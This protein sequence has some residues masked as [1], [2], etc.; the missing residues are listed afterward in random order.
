MRE[1]GR[2]SL[3]RQSASLPLV[4]LF[5]LPPLIPCW[6]TA[7]DYS[8]EYIKGYD[9]SYKAY[10]PTDATHSSFDNTPYLPVEDFDIA[11]ISKEK[12]KVIKLLLWSHVPAG[13]PSL[14]F[15]STLDNLESGLLGLRLWMAFSGSVITLTP[16]A[17]LPAYCAG[18]SCSS[19]EICEPHFYCVMKLGITS[20]Y[21]NRNELFAAV[22]DE[23][24]RACLAE[25]Y[26][27]NPVT[28]DPSIWAC[29][30]SLTS[31]EYDIPELAPDQTAPCDGPQYDFTSDNWKAHKVEKNLKIALED[32]V[33]EYGVF[34]EA[35][36]GQEP[37]AT[38]IG[39]QFWN[40]KSEQCSIKNPCEEQDIDCHNIGSFTGLALSSLGRPMK[41]PW[42]VLV[43]AAVKNLN[44]QLVNI[45]NQVLNAIQ[46]LALDAFSTEDFSP[47]KNPNTD[48]K[49]NLA[50]L[51]SIFTILGG[52]VPVAG[53]TLDLVGAITSGVGSFIANA[54][55]P[56]EF[57]AQRTFAKN[58]L[59]YY[60][61][62]RDGLEKFTTQ[63][64][65]G[66]QISGPVTSFNLFDLMRDGVWVSPDALTDVSQLNRDIRTEV[67]ARSIDAIWKTKTSNKM[68]VLFTDL[69]DDEK[70]TKC[71]QGEPFYHKTSNRYGAA[72][73]SLI[74]MLLTLIQEHE[75][76]E[77]SRKLD[78]PAHSVRLRD[79]D[80]RK[81]WLIIPFYSDTTGPNATKYCADRGMYYA[82]NFIEKGAGGGNVGYPWG[83]EQLEFWTNI[84]LQVRKSFKSAMLLLR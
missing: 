50:G 43:S 83:S 81:L 7:R 18:A 47:A 73:S 77:Q 22:V 44:L 45:Y 11:T 54:A 3:G 69:Q 24:F 15:N 35:R 32:G 6:H 65:A 21:I 38:T 70:H 74:Q 14:I 60:E 46:S 61:G 36:R 12:K 37:I 27:F 39:R 28:I 29:S 79:W 25:R 72:C 9:L 17:S 31:T 48:I 55:P 33:D 8:P 53:P 13:P 1:H 67:T 16:E 30:I 5:L 51:G 57:A 76:L 75:G 49:N 52:I 82:Y 10:S 56:D 64:F 68:W 42:V 78:H 19:K 34:W 84:P 71:L 26:N 62:L 23:E 20:L 41:L 66:A 40:K 58:V 2:T 59:T 63:L 80:F 4:V